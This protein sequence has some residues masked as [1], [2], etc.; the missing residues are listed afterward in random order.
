MNT[1]QILVVDD[2]A[3]GADLVARILRQKGIT[4]SITS[5]AEAALDVLRTMP[6]ALKAV[7]IDLALPNMDGIELM[8]RIRSNPESARLY[9]IAITAFDTP[10]LKVRAL[11]TGFDAY[12]A[13]PLDASRFAREVIQLF[14]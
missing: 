3:D 14:A 9:L 11:E 2:E 12:F 6:D 4:S 13:K 5:T 1:Y 7:V 10:E 8:R